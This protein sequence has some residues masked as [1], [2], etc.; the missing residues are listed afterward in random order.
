VKK[1]RLEAPATA[2]SDENVPPRTNN[3]RRKLPESPNS[4]FGIQNVCKRTK[5]LCETK[6]L[7]S[8]KTENK[9]RVEDEFSNTMAEFVSYQLTYLANDTE[10]WETIL[11]VDYDQQVMTIDLEKYMSDATV[12]SD[13]FF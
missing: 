11:N 4:S 12:D 6:N 7:P 10:F 8:A 5:T 9:D 13:M 1:Q 2:P 3:R